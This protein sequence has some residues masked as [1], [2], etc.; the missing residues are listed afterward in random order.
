MFFLRPRIPGEHSAGQ[1]CDKDSPI[2]LAGHEAVE[3]LAL[4]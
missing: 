3:L 4:D 2:K 1:E